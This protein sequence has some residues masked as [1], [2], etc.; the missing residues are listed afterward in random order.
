MLNRFGI[1]LQNC[2]E[3]SLLATASKRTGLF[4]FGDEHFRAPLRVLLES[5][6][7]NN[8]AAE[9][10]MKAWL[11]NNPQHK[12]GVHRYSL[13]QYGLEPEMVRQR[14]EKY[15]GLFHVQRE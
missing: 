5:Y 12:H 8:A 9:E 7:K 3:N 14:F 13:E 15:Y 4:D 6:K 2:S 10:H 11:V 1:F